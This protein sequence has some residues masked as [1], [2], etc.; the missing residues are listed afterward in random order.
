M[1][2]SIYLVNGLNDEVTLSLNSSE[3]E[4]KNFEVCFSNNQVNIKDE[5]F[6]KIISMHVDLSDITMDY[7]QDKES[8]DGTILYIFS[9]SYENK[10]FKKRKISNKNI[11]SYASKELISLINLNKIEIIDEQSALVIPGKKLNKL[12]ITEIY[13]ELVLHPVLKKIHKSQLLKKSLNKSIESFDEAMKIPTEDLVNFDE[14]QYLEFKENSYWV[15]SEESARKKHM[16]SEYIPGKVTSLRDDILKEICAFGNSDGGIILIG[17]V[18]PKNGGGICG[19]EQD[20][21]NLEKLANQDDF[22]LYW[23]DTI[24]ANIDNWSSEE[25]DFEFEIINNKKV[26]RVTIPPRKKT[27]GYCE[28]PHKGEKKVYVRDGGRCIAIETVDLV[29]KF[30]DRF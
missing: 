3:Y 29:N 4:N 14:G 6:L 10:R 27:Y 15:E 12:L 1:K 20:I 23:K 24:K 8:V 16:G 21:V 13:S 11:H 28:T 18:D 17:V 9:L 2:D 5:I 30:R 26:V 25:T 7:L 19:I 22:E